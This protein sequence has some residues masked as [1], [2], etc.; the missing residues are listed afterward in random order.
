LEN[1]Q[2]LSMKYRCSTEPDSY[3]DVQ[4]RLTGK[5]FMPSKKITQL[6]KY[7][8]QLRK[9]GK[10]RKISLLLD[11]SPF[12][13]VKDSNN[14]VSLLDVQDINISQNLPR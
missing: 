8:M 6:E 7:K 12:E 11:K 14:K 3:E 5:E 10:R 9:K 2:F 4:F 1:S 13:E